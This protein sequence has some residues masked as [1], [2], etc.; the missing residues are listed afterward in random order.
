MASGYSKWEI[1]QAPPLDQLRRDPRYG[2]IANTGD[3]TRSGSEGTP[4]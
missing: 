2:P 4:K 1:E 3:A